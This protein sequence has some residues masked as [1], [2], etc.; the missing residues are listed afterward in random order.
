MWSE[1]DGRYPDPEG[2][3]LTTEYAECVYFH[4][5]IRSFLY[6]SKQDRRQHFARQTGVKGKSVRILQ[7]EDTAGASI[8]APG[9]P[10]PSRALP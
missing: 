3:N 4:P 2:I 1:L 8:A 5:F 6:E 10:T 9:A 7:R